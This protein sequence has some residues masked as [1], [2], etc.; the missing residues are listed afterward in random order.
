MQSNLKPIQDLCI[1][2]CRL[3]HAAFQHSAWLPSKSEEALRWLSS[4]FSTSV[5]QR[6]QPLPPP[7]SSSPYQEIHISCRCCCAWAT[8]CTAELGT[9]PGTAR[10]SASRSPC[11]GLRRY[12]TVHACPGSLVSLGWNR[13]DD[14]HT[15]TELAHK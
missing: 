14:I 5:R 6:E 2:W 7:R 15:T 12:D 10:Y 13:V 8:H 4:C 3:S 11:Y 9:Q 1:A